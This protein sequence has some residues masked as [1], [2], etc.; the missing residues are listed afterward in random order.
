[1]KYEGIKSYK[2]MFYLI[3]LLRVRIVC[4]Y[5]IVNYY[6]LMEDVASAVELLA[7]QV[8]VGSTVICYHSTRLATVDSLN[9]F[10]S[11]STSAFKDYKNTV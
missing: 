1:M 7:N 6:I 8:I 2:L 11:R 9:H 4:K 10:R 5:R 3:K